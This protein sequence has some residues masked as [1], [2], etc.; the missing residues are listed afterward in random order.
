MKINKK[1]SDWSTN[2]LDFNSN[3][4]KGKISDLQDC[5]KE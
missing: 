4:V 1:Y 2:V 5:H 3:T